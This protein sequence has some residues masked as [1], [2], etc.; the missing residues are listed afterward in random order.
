MGGH[1]RI[2]V[3]LKF[4]GRRRLDKGHF[5][6]CQGGLVISVFLAGFGGEAVQTLKK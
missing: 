3:A 6:S 1:E 2:S 5:T 4:F